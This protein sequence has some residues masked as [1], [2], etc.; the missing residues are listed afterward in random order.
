MP[1]IEVSCPSCGKEN[2]VEMKLF[3]P[4]NREGIGRMLESL[5]GDMCRRIY[6]FNGENRCAKCGKEIEVSIEVK[7]GSEKMEPDFI[8]F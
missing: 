7:S 6:T 2:I 8:S 4:L 5:F 1:T 3:E